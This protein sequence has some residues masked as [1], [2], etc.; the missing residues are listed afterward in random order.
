VGQIQREVPEHGHKRFEE[1]GA[2]KEMID[3]MEVRILYCTS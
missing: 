1:E 3:L 2:K